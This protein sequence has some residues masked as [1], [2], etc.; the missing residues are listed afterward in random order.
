MELRNSNSG[1]CYAGSV[2]GGTTVDTGLSH[3]TAILITDR[4]YN[5]SFDGGSVRLW[6][7]GTLYSLN[8][9]GS[10]SYTTAASTITVSG[11]K[12]TFPAHAGGYKWQFIAFQ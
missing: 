1:G 4:V 9:Y 8:A 2:A 10:N 3:I 12:I 6:I 5:A 7:A 11:G